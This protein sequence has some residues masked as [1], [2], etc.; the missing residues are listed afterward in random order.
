MQRLNGREIFS[1]IL[2]LF[3]SSVYLFILLTDWFS[4]YGD[5]WRALKG[6]FQVNTEA[7]KMTFRRLFVIVPGLTGGILLLRQRTTGWILSFSTLLF[8][9]GLA[10]YLFTKSFALLERDVLFIFICLGILLLL[11]ATIFLLFPP[12][13]KKFRVGKRT[14]LPTLVLFMALIA[15]TFFL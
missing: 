13:L 6:M 14:I 3:I 12:T 9:S 11:L 4:A 1:G 7:L 5:A 15:V 2:L 10:L 8:H